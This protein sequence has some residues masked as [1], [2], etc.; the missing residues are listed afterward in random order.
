MSAASPVSSTM[1]L[2]RAVAAVPPSGI[3]EFFD[4]VSQMEDVISLGVGEPDF[5][6]AWRVREA[7]IYGL[8]QGR[9]TYTA[10]S[11]LL[12]LRSAVASSLAGRY[13]LEYDPEDEI[14]ITVGVS[15]GLDLALRAVL[16]P[17][18]EVLIPEP[19]YVSYGP[20]TL[21]AGGSP[22]YVPAGRES[23]FEVSVDE[24][25]RRI[26]PRTR[27]ILIGYPNNPTGAVMPRAELER[28]ARLAAERDL[29]VIS[30]EIYD[31]LVY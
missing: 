31:R 7:A 12:D 15:E 28:L 11:G 3:R 26:G 14:L 9:T 13:G 18:D 25:A 6:T 4:V 16:D 17:G 22:I 19:S 5:G 10:N 24:I 29:L 1:R 21:L 27:A 30:D 2:S 23:D 20:C 8:E